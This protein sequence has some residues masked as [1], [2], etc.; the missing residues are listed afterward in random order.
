M[1]II[2]AIDIKEGR[3]VRLRQGRMDDETIFAE[4][5]VEMADKWIDAGAKRL[6][7]VDLDGASSGAP[8]NFEIIQ[9]RNVQSEFEFP[10]S[11]KRFRE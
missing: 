9:G 6:H 1:I 11:G 8:R 10:K 5:P 4:N 7:I 3:C 2:P